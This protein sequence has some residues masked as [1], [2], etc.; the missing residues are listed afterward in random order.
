MLTLTDDKNTVGMKITK[1]TYR[2]LVSAI[3]NNSAFQNS[4]TKV[5]IKSVNIIGIYELAWTWHR[6]Q[7]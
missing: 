7:R 6:P 4:Q 3:L 1:K 2:Y 5:N